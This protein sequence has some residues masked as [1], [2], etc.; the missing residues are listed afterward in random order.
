MAKGNI[1]IYYI[2]TDV[3]LK[4]IPLI[5]FIKNTSGT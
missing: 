1:T 3:L 2:D 5:K 4:N